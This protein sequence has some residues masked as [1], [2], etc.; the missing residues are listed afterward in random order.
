MR[1]AK[2]ELIRVLHVDDE[3][4]FA[5]LTAIYLERERDN[6]AVETALSGQEAL[7]RVSEGN[8]RIDCIVSDY[9]MPGMNGLEVLE[10]IRAINADVPFIL[11]T[12]SNREG[13]ESDAL[14]AGASGYLSKHGGIHQYARLANYIETLVE[15]DQNERQQ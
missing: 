1:T 15:T 5:D 8:G 3:P 6:L 12:G 14:S 7:T 4:D 9:E 10:R 11:F 13:I 2:P